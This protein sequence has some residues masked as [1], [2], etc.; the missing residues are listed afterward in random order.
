[1]N[2]W[3]VLSVTIYYFIYNIFLFQHFT[4][5]HSAWSLV[6]C[7]PATTANDLQLRRIS[8]PDFI[9][10]IFCPICIVQKEPVF[11][12]L[13]LSAK[14]GNYWYHFYITSLVWRGPWLGIEPGTSRT[15]TY[16]NFKYFP[17]NNKFVWLFNKETC[18]T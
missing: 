7:I 1:M 17:Q 9:H 12:F 5:V 2:C 14:Q 16:I 6:F 13:M 18:L 15:Q 10:Y 4:F 3:L 8:I 11:H